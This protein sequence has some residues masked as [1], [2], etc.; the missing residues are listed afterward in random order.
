MSYLLMEL[1]ELV[2]RVVRRLL[3]DGIIVP[4]RVFVLLQKV[5][6]P[7]LVVYILMW[8]GLVRGGQF[9][10]LRFRVI[11]IGLVRYHWHVCIHDLYLRGLGW[12]IRESTV[13]VRLRI[14][15]FLYNDVLIH[16]FHVSSRSP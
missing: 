2:K 14:T 16:V 8:V 10:L 6:V 3:V 11:V 9:L 12:L 4:Y 13:V 15:V 1:V 5:S 7:G